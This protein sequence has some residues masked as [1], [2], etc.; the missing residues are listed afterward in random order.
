MVT[1][2][3]SCHISTSKGWTFSVDQITDQAEMTS[4]RTDSPAMAREN[5][6]TTTSSDSADGPPGQTD[7]NQDTAPAM[8]ATGEKPKRGRPRKQSTA[9]R[10]RTVELNLTITGTLDGDW[11]AELTHSGERVVSG[12]QIPAASVARAAR[13]LNAEI[14][15]HIDSVIT[16]AKE[17]HLARVAELEAQLEEAK[18]ALAELES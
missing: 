3:K 7:Q 18:K 12:M 4:A 1:R 10:I 6:D 13:E 16:A 5:T 9:R 14:S 8:N 2:R 11:Q 15:Q 17:Q